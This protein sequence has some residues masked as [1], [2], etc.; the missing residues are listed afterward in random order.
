M[1]SAVSSGHRPEADPALLAFIKCH[2]R[3]VATWDILCVL[4]R[5]VGCWFT[6][7]QLERELGMPPARVSAALRDLVHDGIIEPATDSLGG[8]FRI[9]TGEPTTIVIERLFSAARVD[10]NLRRIVVA[11]MAHGHEAP[12]AQH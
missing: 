3:S 2:V 9:P 5:E 8:V 12:V 4:A 10:Q 6:Q 11:H 1:N 7:D